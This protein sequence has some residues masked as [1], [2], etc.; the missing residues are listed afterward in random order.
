MIY[1]YAPFVTD[2]K[3]KLRT[4]SH[5]R[6]GTQANASALPIGVGFVVVSVYMR[7]CM[8]PGSDTDTNTGME[9]EECQ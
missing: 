7:T 3:H 2:T 1:A 5:V 6:F 8:R 4:R 9:A